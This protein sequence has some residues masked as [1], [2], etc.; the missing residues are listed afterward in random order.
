A[1]R[2]GDELRLGASGRAAGLDVGG[3][4]APVA[5]AARHPRRRLDRVRGVSA[6]Q[7]VGG[8]GR[9]D[10]GRRA[11]LRRGRLGRRT[12]TLLAASVLL[13]GVIAWSVD[14]FAAVDGETLAAK[15]TRML[16]WAFATVVVVQAGLGAL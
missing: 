4:R 5:A 6:D 10:I 7:R 13:L 8:G 1:D 15:A 3:A 11:G 2:L 9:H 12:M 14:R 16:L